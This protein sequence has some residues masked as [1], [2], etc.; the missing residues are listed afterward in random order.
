MMRY[1]LLFFSILVTT[2]CTSTAPLVPI[3]FD[4]EVLVATDQTA[5]IKLETGIINGSDGL[6]NVLGDRTVIPIAIG[7]YPSLHFGIDDQ[8]VFVSSL[9]SELS[10]NGILDVI[11][12]GVEIVELGEQKIRIIFIKTIHYSNY[13]VYKLHAAMQITDGKHEFYNHYYIV[14]HDGL[15]DRY[16]TDAAGGKEKAAKQL[17][18]LMVDDIQRYLS[19]I[20]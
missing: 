14:S 1:F 20:K 4:R 19:G 13:Q 2:G 17:I 15:K 7:Q 3:S 16:F 8:L 6:S 11:D 12:N 9:S 10:R 18:N 5:S